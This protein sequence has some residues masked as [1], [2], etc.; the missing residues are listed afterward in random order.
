MALVETGTLQRRRG[1]VR[2]VDHPTLIPRKKVT[3]PVG[4]VL[5]E[6]EDNREHAT[7]SP[8]LSLTDSTTSSSKKVNLPV[9]VN[10][11][12]GMVSTKPVS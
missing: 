4:G 11:V 12:R 7:P 8:S 3:F 9:L 5:H 6:V 1:G 2:K 10:L